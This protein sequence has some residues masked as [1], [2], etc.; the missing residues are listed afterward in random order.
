MHDLTKLFLADEFNIKIEFNVHQTTIETLKQLIKDEK[1]INMLNLG[2]KEFLNLLN[3]LTTAKNKR[4][5]AQYY[6]GTAF[7]KE[8]YKKEAFDFLNKLV[9]PYINKLISIKNAY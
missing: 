9:M 5:K 3:D 4:T 7:M 2:Y 8:K 6:T 1:I